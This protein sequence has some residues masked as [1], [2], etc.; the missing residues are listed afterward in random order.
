MF[1]RKNALS[2]CGHNARISDLMITSLYQPSPV[3]VF[4]VIKQN[5]PF[6]TEE[7]TRVTSDIY[8]L[9]NQQRLDRLTR[10]QLIRHFD[11]MQ[12]QDKSFGDLR[13]KLT[14]DDLIKFVKSRYIQAPSELLAWS[15][16]LTSIASEEI[17]QVL[18]QLSN[19]QA[20]PELKPEQVTQPT[21][22]AQPAVPAT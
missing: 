22:P 10:E 2:S 13:T 3:D 15:N 6:D 7:S 8:M 1:I 14:D 4:T 21:E 16:Y 11:D 5:A 12:V 20:K 18:S 9:F 19:E 17:K